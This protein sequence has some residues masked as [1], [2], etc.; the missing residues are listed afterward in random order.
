M[1]VVLA[2]K[3]LRYKVI[4][5]KALAVIVLKVNFCEGAEPVMVGT[6]TIDD[7]ADELS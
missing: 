1:E 5:V 6:V 2:T 7:N 3:H 4:T